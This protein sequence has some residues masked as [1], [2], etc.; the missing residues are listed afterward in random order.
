MAT[1]DPFDEIEGFFGSYIEAFY[2]GDPASLDALFEYPCVFSTPESVGT[3]ENSDVYREVSE[4]FRRSGIVTTRYD[5]LRKIRMGQD[6]AMVLAEYSRLRADG[7][8]VSRGS[9][10]YVLRHRP[11]GWKLIAMLDGFGAG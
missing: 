9:G 8:V 2:S 5:S 1:R 7:S 11:D 6:G 4:S 3:L 10:A